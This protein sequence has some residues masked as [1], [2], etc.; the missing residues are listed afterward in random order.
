M[1][2]IAYAALGCLSL[3]MAWFFSKACERL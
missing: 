1:A 2:D 3:L